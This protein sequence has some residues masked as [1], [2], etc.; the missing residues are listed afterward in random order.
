M[1]QGAEFYAAD[2]Q[3]ATLIRAELQGADLTGAD[4]HSAY[5]TGADLHGANLTGAL[6]QGADLAVADLHGANLTG[7][8][9][10]EETRWPDGW[11]QTR[12]AAAGV[13]SL[14]AEREHEARFTGDVAQRSKEQDSSGR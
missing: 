13:R 11:D 10:S 14:E 9:A 2:L 5:L 7:A 6:L 4:L 1:L 3:G 12:I 8:L